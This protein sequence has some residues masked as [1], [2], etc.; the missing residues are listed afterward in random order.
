MY[1]VFVDKSYWH[2]WNVH[3]MERSLINVLITEL[4]II[5]FCMD[6]STVTCNLYFDD[7][8]DRSGQDRNRLFI[9]FNYQ[10][11]AMD[12]KTEFK[13]RIMSHE[14]SVV[15]ALYNSVYNQVLYNNR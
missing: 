15:S 11:T 2:I 9:S 1:N 12:M 7:S 4:L 14:K 10:L 5:Y 6:L 13:D 8:K 3:D